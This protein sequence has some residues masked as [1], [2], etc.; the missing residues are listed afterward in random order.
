MSYIVRQNSLWSKFLMRPLRHA[1]LEARA[2][3][4]V[5]Q[6]LTQYAFAHIGLVSQ[7]GKD[8]YLAL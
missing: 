4:S 2:G 7:A 1:Y 5:R 8:Y 3:Q 6:R